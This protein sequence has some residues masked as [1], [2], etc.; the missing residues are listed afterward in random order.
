[1]GGG[2][3]H[4]RSQ[5]GP[6]GIGEGAAEGHQKQPE[7]QGRVTAAQRGRQTSR[8]VVVQLS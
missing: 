1:V 4:R 3:D 6:E 5:A 2:D 8:A 7:A